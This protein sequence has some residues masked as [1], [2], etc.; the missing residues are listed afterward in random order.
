MSGIGVQT[1]DMFK[2]DEKWPAFSEVWSTHKFDAGT[3]VGLVNEF[4]SVFVA[5]FI[6]FCL[7]NAAIPCHPLCEVELLMALCTPGV[8]DIILP[9]KTCNIYWALFIEIFLGHNVATR[10]SQF[11]WEVKLASALALEEGGPTPVVYLGYTVFMNEPSEESSI[12]KL[13]FRWRM[14]ESRRSYI[15]RVVPSFSNITQY[16]LEGFKHSVSTLLL[17]FSGRAILKWCQWI[18]TQFVN[19]LL[20]PILNDTH[21]NWGWCSIKYVKQISGIG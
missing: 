1:I 5:W 17:L 14:V 15:L 9:G 11:F 19:V 3:G 16:S 20:D 4:E 13:I 12:W 18:Q 21:L 7:S 8:A 6:W 10:C 2:Q